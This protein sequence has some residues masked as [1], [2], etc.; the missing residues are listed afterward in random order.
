[1]CMTTNQSKER[2][3]LIKRGS[4]RVQYLTVLAKIYTLII[5]V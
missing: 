1:M 4:K 2:Q 5:K 3:K